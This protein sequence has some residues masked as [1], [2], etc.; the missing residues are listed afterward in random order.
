MKRLAFIVAVVFLAFVF[1]MLAN[2]D[3]GYVLIARSPWSIEMSLTVF[4]I[5]AVLAVAIAYLAARLISRTRKIPSDVAGWRQR[6][7]AKQ[8]RSALTD[9]LSSLAACD[10]QEAETQLLA[11]LRFSDAPMINY[12]GAAIAA[13]GQ[14]NLAKRD[15]YLAEAGKSAPEGSIAAG[16]TQ[17]FLQHLARQQEQALATLT[18]LRNSAPENTAALKLLKD[19]YLEMHDWTGIMNLLPDLK[20][21]KALDD[22]EI[23][24]LE[25]GTYK[26][27]LTLS[28]PSGSLDVL[29]AAWQNIPAS[30]QT[31]PE[32]IGL[33]TSKL[34]QQGEHDAAEKLLRKAIE[35]EWDANLVR[36]Y[37]QTVSQNIGRQLETAR[38]WY[39]SQ[40]KDP[41]MLIALG[42]L[43]LE[44]GDMDSAKDYLKSSLE[45]RP[46][47][48]GWL[49]LGRAY[50]R[51]GNAD[52]ARDA[53][54]QGL[55][56]SQ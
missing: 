13:Q 33:Y 12:L 43:A 26:A 30:L 7:H 15:D 1:V 35:K 42:Q 14:D 32:I 4:T 37:G 41:G 52:E 9:G 40:P 20:K 11:G 6:R 21:Q 24:E 39:I 51:E 55:T 56:L 18:G 10:W 29:Q 47:P 36:L 23:S 31:H 19:T 38:S 50:E 46:E 2:V 27:L 49:L 34:I 16:M 48:A 25:I 45:I 54:R 28:L 5:I 53:Y 17:A 22:N 8:A 3:P 44:N